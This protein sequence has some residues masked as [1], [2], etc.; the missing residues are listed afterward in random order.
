MTITLVF[1]V[2]RN[3]FWVPVIPLRWN[4]W[5]NLMGI[6]SHPWI[7]NFKFNVYIYIYYIKSINLMRILFTNTSML[8]I[9][10]KR[11]FHVRAFPLYYSFLCYCFTTFPLQHMVQLLVIL[12][13]SYMVPKTINMK[14]II[15]L[16]ALIFIVEDCW[17]MVAMLFSYLNISHRKGRGGRY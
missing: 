14:K 1:R 4:Q 5:L 15:N 2:R 8:F 11:A 13:V 17:Y 10:M 7:N 9:Y 12:C 6:I 16:A 3:A